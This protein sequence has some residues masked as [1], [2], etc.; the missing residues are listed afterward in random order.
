M[1]SKSR[2]ILT[3]KA[4]ASRKAADIEYRL[5]WSEIDA[6]WEIYRN[7][8]KTSASRRKKQSAIDMAILAIQAEEKSPDAKVI[9]TSLKDRTLKTEWA[10]PSN[11]SGGA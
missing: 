4:P 11:K 2:K 6:H 7:G 10:G 8:A 9:V 3:L 1:L 5:V